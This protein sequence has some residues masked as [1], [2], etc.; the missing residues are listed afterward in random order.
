MLI[1][2]MTEDDDPQLLRPHYQKEHDTVIEERH[3]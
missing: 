2:E 1:H 3:N